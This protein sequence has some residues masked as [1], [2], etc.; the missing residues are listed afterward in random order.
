[1]QRLSQSRVVLR[2]GPHTT[3]LIRAE[4]GGIYPLAAIKYGNGH[5]LLSGV[6]LSLVEAPLVSTALKNLFITNGGNFPLQ[7][8]ELGACGRQ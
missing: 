3:P 7:V 8:H 1:M 2:D 6:N 4:D 5:L